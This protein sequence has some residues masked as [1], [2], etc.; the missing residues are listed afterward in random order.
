VSFTPSAS[1]R[2]AIQM[3]EFASPQL[4][5]GA[6]TLVDAT[7]VWTLPDDR[8]RISLQGRNLTDERYRV[9]GYNFPGALTGDSII[10]FYGPPRTFTAV[11]EA[12]F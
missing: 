3:F 9:G 4:D 6:Y 10:G 8:F 11:F 7:A 1:Y 5:Q 2:G 12:T